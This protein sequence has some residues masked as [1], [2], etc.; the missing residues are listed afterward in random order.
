MIIATKTHPSVNIKQR[1]Q[2]R[3]TDG[4]SHEVPLLSFIRN[5][6][7]ETEMP[8]IHK[9]LFAAIIQYN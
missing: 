8:T 6:M 2:H 4:T 9:S 5:T 3:D 1:K 7:N